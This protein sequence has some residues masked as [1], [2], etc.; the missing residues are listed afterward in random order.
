MEHT[1]ESGVYL[2][3]LKD[4]HHF[5]F[6]SDSG[7]SDLFHS[8]KDDRG[9]KYVPSRFFSSDEFHE[10]PKEN[11]SLQKQE[12]NSMSVTPKKERTRESGR[13]VDKDL[14]RE[15]Q[16]SSGGWCETPKVSKRDSSLRRRLLMCKS[17]TDV[18]TETSRT[19][20]PTRTAPSA[21]SEH[22]STAFFDSPDDMLMWAL[23][24]ST[25]KPELDVPLS[26]RKRR[27][28]FSQVRT[29]TREDGK[30]SGVDLSNFE[31]KV[32]LSDEFLLNESIISTDQFTTQML[33]TPRLS[34]FLPALVKENFQTPVNNGVTAKLSDG[35]S[36][37]RTPLSTP[38]LKHNRYVYF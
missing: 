30:Q 16:P 4:Q 37:L 6:A 29:S 21:R 17:A 20:C 3:S 11:F 10:T 2:Q 33:E 18:K 1:P 14:R 35:P 28:L 9:A 22:Y 32:S 8:P 34:K 7:Y 25:F 27:L 38:I 24:T 12:S 15:Q 5:G 36:I 13:F 19:P 23:A 26:G 31:R